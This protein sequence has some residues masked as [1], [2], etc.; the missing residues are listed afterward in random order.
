M[1][2]VAQPDRPKL[3]FLAFHFPPSGSVAS[4]RAANIA[5]HLSCAGWDISVAIPDPDAVAGAR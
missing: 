5:K 4:V 2:N 1:N 3:L